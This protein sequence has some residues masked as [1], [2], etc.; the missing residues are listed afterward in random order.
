MSLAYNMR[1]R[2]ATRGP[3][4]LTP[5]RATLD[6]GNA[7]PTITDWLLILVPSAYGT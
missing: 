4:L 7:T 3:K 1:G 6:V 5:V 2:S